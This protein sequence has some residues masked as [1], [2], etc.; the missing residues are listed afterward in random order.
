MK[1]L[2]DFSYDF[3][4]HLIIFL[5]SSLGF[6]AALS[7]NDFV[8][9]V[10]AAVFPNSDGS[11]IASFLYLGFVIVASIILIYLLEKYK[12]LIASK[13]EKIHQKDTHDTH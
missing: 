8:K 11:V 4:N 7:M 10:Y 6:V 1:F 5:L 9:S 13:V 12:M 3:M 2:S